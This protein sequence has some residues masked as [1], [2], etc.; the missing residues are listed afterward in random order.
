MEVILTDAHQRAL[1]AAVDLNNGIQVVLWTGR[2]GTGKST[3]LQVYK[4][5][6]KEG[7]VV[8][9]PTGLAALNVKGETIHSFFQLPHGLLQFEGIELRS[10]A[11]KSDRLDLIR[12]VHTI[13]IDEVSMVRA[14]LMDAIDYLLRRACR[15]NVPFA[16]K[17]IILIGDL[18]QLPPVVG[19]DVPDGYFTELYDSPFFFSSN[20]ISTSGSFRVV[21]L[22]QVFRQ[23]D[24]KFI[25]ALNAVRH[26]NPSNKV[27][28]YLNARVGIL[29]ESMDNCTQLRTRNDDVERENAAHLAEIDSEEFEYVAEIK[30]NFSL[31]QLPAPQVLKLKVGAKVMTLKNKGPYVNG[32]IGT[33]ESLTAKTVRVRLKNNIV[34]EIEK[35]EWGKKTYRFNP[36][37]KTATAHDVSSYLQ[38]PLRLAWASTI[39]KAQGMTLDSAVIDL[40]RG[41][42]AH[43]QLY[44]ALSRVRS[45]DGLFL[46]RAI[47]PYEA[48]VDGKVA[49]FMR[50]Y[51]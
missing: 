2:A 3:L 16:G 5:R 29:P 32:S 8:L 20:V 4:K 49:E 50:S 26:G 51:T 44:V 47:K 13:I 45:Y 46:T 23:T 19:N 10:M 41:A 7:Y 14:D 34:V 48:I 15:S 42:F 40:G 17:K 21:E 30:G 9:A 1:D 37:S 35:A 25:D 24:A 27:M 12:S 28:D 36:E 38:I 11:Y 33:V 22:T 18:Y 31:T 39:H 6:V 43:G